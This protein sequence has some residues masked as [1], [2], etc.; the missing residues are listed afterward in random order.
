MFSQRYL[1]LF[2]G[3]IGFSGVVYAAPT[4]PKPA[5]ASAASS[6]GAV[7]TVL[8]FSLTN[9]SSWMYEGFCFPLS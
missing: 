3:A 9:L 6:S 5:A 2:L 4:S 7:S 1:I 8:A